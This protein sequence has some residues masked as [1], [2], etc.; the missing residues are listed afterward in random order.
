MIGMHRSQNL[1]IHVYVVFGHKSDTT[2]LLIN[3]A[4]QV[5]A[6]LIKYLQLSWGGGGVEGN[7]WEGYIVQMSLCLT[8]T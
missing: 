4:G 1:K 5:Q 6:Q 8:L 2:P 3:W 7:S